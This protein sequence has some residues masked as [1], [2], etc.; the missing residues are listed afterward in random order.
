MPFPHGLI[1]KISN[2]TKTIILIPH[3][4]AIGN[5][6]EEIYFGFLKA[7]REKKKLLIIMPY[8]LPWLLKL[9]LHNNREL[10]ELESVYLSKLQNSL[11]FIIICWLITIYFGILR[12]THLILYRLL[13]LSIKERYICPMA[14]QNT[15][16][17]TSGDIKEFSWEIVNNFK[18]EN[19]INDPLDLEFP[20][21]KSNLAKKRCAQLGLP[22][23]AW[24]VCLH[25]RDGG[26]YEDHEHSSNRNANILN[27][28][29]AIQEITSR[30][31]WVIRMGDSSMPPLPSMKNVIDYPFSEE[32]SSF[33]DMY[34]IKNCSFYIGMLSGLY[35]VAVLFQ[36][37]I[38]LTNM[39]SCM[40][41][42]P[43]RKTDI[44]IF[45]NV[46][47]KSLGRN[48]SPFEWP[49]MPWGGHGAFSPENDFV[50]TEN[51]P[52]ELR[53]TVKEYFDR[54]ASQKKTQSQKLLNQFRSD[55]YRKLLSREMIIGDK[56][57]DMLHRYRYASRLDS[58]TGTIAN[59]FLDRH[60][61]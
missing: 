7:R 30:G 26:Y 56:W 34:F 23:K 59:F 13:T 43:L 39:C 33:M 31:G 25:V 15:L 45:K 16:W 40:F 27:Y 1:E 57:A 20:E 9:K 18:W 50:F 52:E 32:K 36:R 53:L 49:S 47:C 35:D 28:I 4:I 55:S 42:Y 14:G 11:I 29:P 54:D 44:G 19:Q 24:F 2:F 10:L 51:S 22:D 46:Y 37:P 38:I 3:P 58:S 48:L 8:Q 6:A 5:Y 61:K 60:F 41:A 21:K 12:A 17:Q